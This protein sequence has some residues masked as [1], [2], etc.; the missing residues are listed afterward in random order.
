MPVKPTP[1]SASGE[2][3]KRSDS[4]KRRSKGFKNVGG[5]ILAERKRSAQ[6]GN[7]VH[8]LRMERQWEEDQVKRHLPAILMAPVNSGGRAPRF[9]VVNVNLSENEPATVEWVQQMRD[10]CNLFA[11]EP[12]VADER[13]CK[14]ICLAA[15][16]WLGDAG[17]AKDKEGLD[18][19]GITAIVNAAGADFQSIKYP[20]NWDCL[21]VNLCSEFES[22]YHQTGT[23]LGDNLQTIFVFMQRCVDSGRKILVHCMT[24]QSR[25]ITICTALLMLWWKWSLPKALNHV[26]QRRRCSFDSEDLQEEL[27]ALAKVN[28]LLVADADVSNKLQQAEAP[29]AHVWSLA[30]GSSPRA[31]PTIRH[32]ASILEAMLSLCEEKVDAEELDSDLAALEDRRTGAIAYNRFK[33]WFIVGTAKAG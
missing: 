5:S 7:A 3:G 24:G 2:R 29:V 12:A 21:Q 17:C 27:V 28:D 11:S 6:G 4:E 18:K 26:L 14:P 33:S 16:L 23:L 9:T 8:P 25:S 13:M 20:S 10:I 30:S 19:L 1:R 32:R 22:A 15:F 31:S